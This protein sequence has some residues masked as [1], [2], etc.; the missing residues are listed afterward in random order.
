MTIPTALEPQSTVSP[1][2]ASVFQTPGGCK[3]LERAYSLHY[4]GCGIRREPILCKGTGHLSISGCLRVT[5]GK[6]L[7]GDDLRGLGGP[8]GRGRDCWEAEELQLP[9]VSKHSAL[10]TCLLRPCQ[11][12][13]VHFLHHQ[14][15]SLPK[16]T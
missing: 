12:Y 2:S 10:G 5:S 16:D 9:G 13:L 1:S 15:Q 11:L 4:P 6:L 14:S 8:S 3:N 7:K